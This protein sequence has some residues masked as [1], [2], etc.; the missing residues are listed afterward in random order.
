MTFSSSSGKLITTAP[1]ASA[2]FKALDLERDACHASAVLITPHKDA[3]V[4][5]G[6]LDTLINSDIKGRAKFVYKKMKTVQFAAF[7]HLLAEMFAIIS[8]HSLNMQRNDLI[9][10]VAVSQICETITSIDSLK[11]HPKWIAISW[12]TGEI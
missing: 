10:S 9:L 11:S 7:C 6:A 8:K 12:N 3:S 2:N 1:R 4:P 5:H